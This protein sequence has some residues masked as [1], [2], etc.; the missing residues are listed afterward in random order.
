MVKPI[1]VIVLNQYI[2]RELSVDPILRNI[3]VLGE[4]TNLRDNRY[5]YFDL[6]E[7]D[8]LINCVFFA[9]NELNIQN[10]D[11]VLVSGSLSTYPRASKYQINVKKIE[12]VGE[13]ESYVQLNKLKNKLFELGY[14][15]QIRKK[16]IPRFPINIGLIT[17]DKSAAIRDFLSILESNY[18]IAK[19]YLYSTR[20][21]GNLAAID[22]IKAIR[23]LDSKD[24]DLIVLTRGGGSNEDLA[25]FNDEGIATAIFKAQTPIIS[26]IGHEI[27]FTISDL[28]C[29]LRVSTPTKAAEYIIESFVNSKEV[30][31]NL[32][33]FN[34]QIISEKINRLSSLV[35]YYHLSNEKHSPMNILQN[36][37][38]NLENLNSS[39]ISNVKGIL[40][41]K[42]RS[43][44]LM[45][46]EIERSFAKLLDLNLMRVRDLKDNYV[47]IQKLDIGKQYY[48]LNDNVKYKIEVLE[49]DDV[50]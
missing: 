2:K 34:E 26:A 1:G 45:N 24:L 38:L 28:V 8:E 47:D 23:F 15:D 48:L 20:V 35:Q 16:A 21:Q 4:V 17:S 50:R 30:L 42:D 29:D 12:K 25:I 32:N 22:I 6:K 10:G 27:D 11:K 39:I 3:Y 31:R 37:I 49:R 46:S 5:L 36:R 41:E 7:E 33:L 14:F 19:V 9:R 18:P 44:N 40:F 43:I 13:G